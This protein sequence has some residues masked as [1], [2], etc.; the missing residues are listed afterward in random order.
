MVS[1]FKI[2]RCFRVD[3]VRTI[4][5]RIYSEAV[6]MLCIEMDVWM[7]YLGER[8][9]VV[10]IHLHLYKANHIHFSLSKFSFGI[11]ELITDDHIALNMFFESILST[12]PDWP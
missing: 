5:N 4:A 10:R 6:F 2:L 1:L 8:N 3:I 11:V 12:G 7:L 9:R